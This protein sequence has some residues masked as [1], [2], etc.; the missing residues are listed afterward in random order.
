MT[1]EIDA[2]DGNPG[3]GTAQCF[4]L[5]VEQGDKKNDE[6]DEDATGNS[7]LLV[8]FHVC[9]DAVTPAG[10]ARRDWRYW[11]LD[12]SEGAQRSTRRPVA[13]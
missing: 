10:L 13:R 2:N 1:S 11:N 8:R 7:D 3:A 6:D 9:C 4:F 5:P 12:R